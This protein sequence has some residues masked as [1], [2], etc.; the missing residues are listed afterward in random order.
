MSVFASTV[1]SFSISALTLGL[2][3]GATFVGANSAEA[4]DYDRRAEYRHGWS[5]ERINCPVATLKRHVKT[6]LPKGWRSQ[7]HSPLDKVEIVAPGSARD[8]QALVCDY[9]EAGTIKRYVAAS[10]ECWTVGT[11]FMCETAYTP[12][13][14]GSDVFSKGSGW[15]KRSGSPWDFDAGREVNN[16]RSDVYLARFSDGRYVLRPMNGARIWW[17]GPNR[18]RGY[19]R[20]AAGGESMFQIGLA[21][22]PKGSELCM[23]TA[24]GRIGK[25]TVTK[26]KPWGK[27]RLKM[28]FKVW[29]DRWADLR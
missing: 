4:R 9:G 6:K 8:R 26:N 11:H 15:L 17:P 19:A 13:A 12:P 14:Y 2:A 5:A 29:E 23:Q 22:L 24:E 21:D 1:K 27:S 20:C 10:R 3:A 25:I 28:K 7:H 18:A 16:R